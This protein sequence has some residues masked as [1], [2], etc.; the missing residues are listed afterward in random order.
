MNIFRG[1][2]HLALVGLFSVHALTASAQEDVD[3]AITTWDQKYA[4]IQEL[5][6]KIK[7][8]AS[9]DQ[10]QELL[11][12]YEEMIADIAK[13]RLE[14]E[15]KLVEAITEAETADDKLAD[16]LLDLAQ[17]D[18]SEERYS[19][20]YALLKPLVDKK[21]EEEAVYQFAAV[22]AYGSDHFVEAKA[23]V[24]KIKADYGTIRVR[25][26]QN[27]ETTLDEQIEAW[28]KEQEIRATEAQANDLPRVK[29][30]TTEGDIV[31]ELYEN[32]AP[33]AVANFIS[34]IEKGF[35]DGLTFHRVLPQFMAQ[36]GCPDGSGTGG[37]GYAIDCEC[38]RPDYRKHFAG[39][40]SMAHAGRDTGGSQFFL[41]FLAT[42]HLDGKHTA[43]GR[44][45]E[46]MDALASLNRVDPRRRNGTPPSKINKA[47]V[48]RKRNHEYKPETH[49]R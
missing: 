29:L 27:A 3:Q 24:D 46:G 48:V 17:L 14:V 34:L 41:T 10:R 31:I 20:A 47:T 7:N 30:E 35:Y 32:Q 49:S 13:Y 25:F 5:I 2:G 36:G 15:P 4:A 21:V 37:P 44:I 12:Q 42:P 19:R 23:I 11:S 33:N 28:K 43:F 1:L 39:T 18:L 26:M 38:Y 8:S 22:A 40:L 45:I 6:P 16:T 9:A